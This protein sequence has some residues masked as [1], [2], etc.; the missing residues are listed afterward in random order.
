MIE[1]FS[2]RITNDHERERALNRIFQAALLHRLAIITSTRKPA[3]SIIVF[4]ADADPTRLS[5]IVELEPERLV[6]VYTRGDSTHAQLLDALKEDIADAARN[7][8]QAA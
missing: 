4:D 8:E 3:R 7:L 6:G 2:V 1:P 5:D